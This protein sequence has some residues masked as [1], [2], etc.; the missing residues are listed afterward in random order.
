[1]KKKL[2]SLALAMSLTL[3]IAMAPTKK[4]HSG[5]LMMTASA[6]YAPNLVENLEFLKFS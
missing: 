3:G 5:V 4:A 2:T 1:M 6:L